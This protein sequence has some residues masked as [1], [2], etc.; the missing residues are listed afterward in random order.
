MVFSRWRIPRPARLPMHMKVIVGLGNPGAEYEDTRH[1]A[2]W[3]LVDH[4]A[5]QW[6]FDSWRK[7][8]NAMIATGTLGSQKV[9]LLKPLTFMNLSG[10]VLRPYIKTE[11]WTPT[12][13][14][15]VV[16]DDIAIPTGQFRLRAAGS[17]G[18]H[19]GLK[20][21]ESHLRTREYPRLRIG[22]KPVD[23]RRSIGNMADFVLQRMPR[24][25]RQMV[26]E[27]FPHLGEVVELWVRSGTQKAVS[28]MGR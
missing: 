20:S 10:A 2:G 26:E 23:E 22:I 16:V 27:L 24:D 13:D 8:G 21:I 18:G 11:D 12:E 15:L 7:N 3:W 6:H 9:R 5:S 28:T 14:L 25:E 19:N 1:N 4:L 17:A